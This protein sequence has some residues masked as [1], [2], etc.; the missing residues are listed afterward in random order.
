MYM[1]MH[2]CLVIQ[3]LNFFSNPSS[4]GSYS[5]TYTCTYNFI[6]LMY[7]DVFMKYYSVVGHACSYHN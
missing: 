7:S 6:I 3:I 4:Y 1:H 5:L 2:T